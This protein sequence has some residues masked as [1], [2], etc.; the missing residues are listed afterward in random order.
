MSL[1]VVQ[2][3]GADFDEAM[4][5]LNGVFG[6]HR[7]HDFATL[8]PSIYQPS[9]EHMACNHALRED[10][11][12]RAVVGLFP[13]DWQVGDRLLKVGGIGGVSTHP[14]VR[15]KGYMG[16]LMRHCV[17]RMKAEGFH[18]SWLGGQR[19]RYGY[20]GYE[21]CGQAVSVDWGRPTCGTPVRR[22]PTCASRLSSPAIPI[23]WN[24]PGGCTRRRT[25]IAGAASP[26]STATC[27]PGT[28][29]PTRPSTRPGRC[30]VTS[31]PAARATR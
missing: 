10:G 1:D 31:W 23:A 27:G 14:G 16:I 25:C 6:E 3:A 24:R 19:Q 11:R 26:G 13:I 9:D 12:I 21:K 22:R 28:T 17:E 2:L 7:P 30:S 5:F 29:A 20:F 18:L 8:L 4:E 15:G